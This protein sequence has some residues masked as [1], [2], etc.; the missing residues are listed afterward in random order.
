MDTLLTGLRAAGERTRLRLLAILARNELTVS[1]LTQILGQSQPRV[2]RHLKLLCEAR[3]LERIPEGTWVFYRLTQRGAGAP[4]AR[5]L[6][7]LIPGADLEIERDLRRLETVRAIRAEAAATYFREN[8]AKWDRIRSLY[9]AES[10]VERAMLKALGDD[11][12]ED[13]LD[14]GTGTGRI[15]QVF[16]TKTNRGL[17]IDLSREMLAVARAN[18]EGAHLQHCQVRHGDIYNLS[19]ATG[20]MDVVTI[21]HVLHFLDDPGAAV[22]EAARTLRPGG[23]LFI[24]DFAPHALEFLRT[25][26][27][28]RRLGF[29][30][31]EVIGWCDSAGLV[32]TDVRHLKVAGKR[33]KEKL[34]VSLWTSTQHQHAPT[35][36]SLEVA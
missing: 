18:L 34:T 31:T 12:V 3:L 11:T 1:E 6:V 24:A 29:A 32:N 25:D 14:L 7:E 5:A 15:L 19:V 30:D 17:G 2:S 13:L 33:D 22:A 35:H 10:E 4:L 26:Y 9:V 36:R 27:S 8:A 20:S 28:H 16:A 21:H 23:R